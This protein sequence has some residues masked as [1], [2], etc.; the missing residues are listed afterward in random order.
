VQQPCLC[1]QG[2]DRTLFP[3]RGV[4]LVRSASP[5]SPGEATKTHGAAQPP[6]PE[7]WTQDRCATGLSSALYFSGKRKCVLVMAPAGSRKTPLLP[8]N[9][10]QQ[11]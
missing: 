3:R 4:R 11:T 10:T 6:C 7:A 1:R 9:I 8:E 5:P 2:W